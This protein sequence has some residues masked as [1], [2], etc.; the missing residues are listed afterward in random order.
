MYGQFIGYYVNAAKSLLIVKPE[1][2]NYAVLKFADTQ[3]EVNTDGNQHLGGFIGTERCKTIYINEKVKEWCDQICT[4]I[5]FAKM[6]PQAAI[7]CIYPWFA[8]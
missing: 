8:T 2:F 6:Q 4:L 5:E 1:H 3:I 7:L